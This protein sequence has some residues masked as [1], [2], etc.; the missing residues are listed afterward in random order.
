MLLFML[1]GLA[2]PAVTHSVQIQFVCLRVQTLRAVSQQF[3]TCIRTD[4]HRAPPSL[5]PPSGPLPLLPRTPRLQRPCSEWS[6]SS[7]CGPQ[8]A[9]LDHFSRSSSVR[10]E[11][12]AQSWQP[13]IQSHTYMC[14]WY[15][16]WAV[17]CRQ[18]RWLNRKRICSIT[19]RTKK[20]MAEGW[21]AQ[22]CCSTTAIMYTM[23]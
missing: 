10:C 3:F 1:A 17:M 9:S 15:G 19:C 20:S 11:A 14:I 4:A 6:S 21:M 8:S 7:S 2:E 5:V 12:F 16:V 22:T 13:N 18:L 23:H